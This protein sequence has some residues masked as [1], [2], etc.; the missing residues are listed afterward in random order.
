V[1]DV[2]TFFPEKDRFTLAMLLNNILA[3]PAFQTWIEGQPLDIP[4]LL[5][6]P[7]GQ[8]RHSV[9]SSLISPTRM[10]ITLLYSRWP[11]YFQTGTLLRAASIS[12]IFIHP[13]R[14]QSCC[15]HAACS[16]CAAFGVAQYWSPRTRSTWI[17]KGLQHRLL[18]HWQAAD[19]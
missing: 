3:A 1:F 14:Q 8:P 9:F 6:T 12:A 10:F 2:N 17:T 13:A 5:Y 16:S 4:A 15:A 19:R 11:G 7:D 18:V